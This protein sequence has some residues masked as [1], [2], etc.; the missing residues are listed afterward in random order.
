MTLV[1][2]LWDDGES[3]MHWL[4]SNDPV[5]ANPGKPG[6]ARGPCS[7]EKWD[8]NYVRSHH[9]DAYVEYFNFKY[10]ELGSTV[11]IGEAPV[12]QVPAPMPAPESVPV[13]VQAPEPAPVPVPTT[14]SSGKCCY[15]GC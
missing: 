13:V 5:S 15:G 6:V 8:P 9:S 2:S 10:G 11:A 14:P 7:A 1:L 4:D 12:H 3:Q